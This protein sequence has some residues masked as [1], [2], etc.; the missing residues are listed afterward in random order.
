MGALP[1]LNFPQRFRFVATPEPAP[2]VAQGA[3]A[4]RRVGRDEADESTVVVAGVVDV[5][6]AGY[7]PYAQETVSQL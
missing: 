6:T 2:Q 7:L 5:Y 3:K 4:P 1:D